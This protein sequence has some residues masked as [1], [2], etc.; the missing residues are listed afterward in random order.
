MGSIKLVL[1][2]D[3]V[4]LIIAA[5][6]VVIAFIAI[7]GLIAW[8]VKTGRQNKTLRQIDDKLTPKEPQIV[9][10]EVVKEKHSSSKGKEDE[11]NDI[12]PKTENIDDEVIKE[13][14]EEPD[15]LEEIR[16]MMI[17]TKQPT[18]A[19]EEKDNYNVG[20]SGKTY[21]REEIEKL[22]ND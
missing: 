15:V 11:K 14:E 3:R 20:K 10:R 18:I 1:N 7:I 13:S 6:V 19:N 2:I 9:I 4:D 12:V 17:S 22:I 8:F 16:K 5:C 21:T